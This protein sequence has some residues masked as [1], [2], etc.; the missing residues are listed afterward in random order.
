MESSIF[1]TSLNS[2]HFRLTQMHST[3]FDALYAVA[4]DPAIWAQHPESNRWQE[5]IFRRFFVAGLANPEGCFLITD[6]D[7]EQAVGSTRFYG[8]DHRERSIWL[9]YTFFLG[10][11]GVGE[12]IRK[13]SKPNPTS[14]FVRSCRCCVF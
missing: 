11:I 5:A 6:K 10:L 2:E 1:R 9:G 7:T 13:L 12:R 14:I 3:D 4:K 8:F